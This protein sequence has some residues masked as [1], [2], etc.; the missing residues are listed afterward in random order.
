MFGVCVVVVCAS[1]CV[2]LVTG[3]MVVLE[4]GM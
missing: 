4:L 1:L 2:I 3:G